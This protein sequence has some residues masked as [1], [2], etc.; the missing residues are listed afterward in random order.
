MIQLPDGQTIPLFPQHEVRSP[1]VSILSG[2]LPRSGEATV[3]ELPEF[4]NSL[5]QAQSILLTWNELVGDHSMMEAQHIEIES[6]LK[7][8][9]VRILLAVFRT[10][11]S[12]PHSPSTLIQGLAQQHQ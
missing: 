8:L 12:K 7:L 4:T 5:G 1:V 6:L 2:L 10:V 3:L 9:M 11:C